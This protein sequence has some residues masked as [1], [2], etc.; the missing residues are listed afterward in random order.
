MTF[1][2]K[3]SNKIISMIL[4]FTMIV[5]ICVFS[6]QTAI[7]AIPLVMP[8]ML[9]LAK[10]LCAL[11]LSVTTTA[12][13]Y[14]ISQRVW[15]AM[16][17]D[18]QEAI[19][20]AV[21]YP[22]GDYITLQPHVLGAI[23]TALDYVVTGGYFTYIANAELALE[24]YE[25][26]MDSNSHSVYK[27]FVRTY[28]NNH[29]EIMIMGEVVA[30]GGYTNAVTQPTEF[31]NIIRDLDYEEDELGWMTATRRV[32]PYIMRDE[33]IPY[34]D[35]F[36]KCQPLTTNSLN[37][38]KAVDP[39][40]T[41][42]VTQH[43][44]MQNFREI[45]LDEVSSMRV[46][47][48]GNFL[49][50]YLDD[51]ENDMYDGTATDTRITYVSKPSTWDFVNN[52]DTIIRY[53]DG[54]M[55]ASVLMQAN[56]NEFVTKTVEFSSLLATYGYD[57]VTTARVE[58]LAEG[59]GVYEKPAVI[60]DTFGVVEAGT[61]MEDVLT[62]PREELGTTGVVTTGWLQGILQGIQ[63]AVVSAVQSIA[64]A[65]ENIWSN[66][67]EFPGFKLPGLFLAFFGI[68]YSIIKL[69]TRASI[70]VI[71]IFNIP[72]D[73]SLLNGNTVAGLQMIKN[74][75]LPFGVSLWDFFSLCMVLVL[76]FIIVRIAKN[77][78]RGA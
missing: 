55:V 51:N 69:V 5:L 59:T 63:S 74:I 14:S 73:S 43:Q 66:A 41:F 15:Q 60:P 56:A 23:V 40:F 39:D 20:I 34:L 38:L 44:K 53:E 28:T 64:M 76:A 72:A 54:R 47:I 12:I 36:V 70:F 52:T 18:I 68:L 19:Q 62:M 42:E 9:F 78:I 8:V 50:V 30:D 2:I 1:A 6:F 49:V 57:D 31:V 16:P 27:P 45:K 26:Y 17:V 4:V 61:T 11:G 3:R 37:S 58:V 32:Y 35:L 65:I 33:P 48:T 46:G 7:N 67:L 75:Q 10:V 22:I 21:S 13:L 25:V 24:D 77:S 71:S 29:A